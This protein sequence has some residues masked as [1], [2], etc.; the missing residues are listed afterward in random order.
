MTYY[1]VA[2]A[3]RINSTLYYILKDHL[4]SA[5]VVTDA[6][7]TILGEQ[8][9]YPFG[10]TRLTTGTIYTD[11]LFTG[12]REMAGL[13]IYH[14]QARFYSPK[15][16][17]FLSADTIVPN[18]ANPQSLNRYSY[19]YN[20]PL[21][22]V[23]PSGHDPWWCTSSDCVSD[24]M[25]TQQTQ[26][27]A[28]LE[29]AGGR[30]NDDEDEPNEPMPDGGLECPANHPNCGLGQDCGAGGMNNCPQP[31]TVVNAPY[32]QV[33]HPIDSKNVMV[34]IPIYDFSHHPPRLI[35]YRTTSYAID[36]VHFSPVDYIIPS[37]AITFASTL[38]SLAGELLKP[39][40]RNLTSMGIVTLTC[41]ECTVALEI[42]AGLDS[43]NG[44]ITF[45]A[46][47]RTH[48]V[49]FYEPLFEMPFE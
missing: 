21:N 43:A 26:A 37:D 12:Q 1:P 36:D 48:D 38:K 47:L 41:P 29:H 16:G 40:L 45:D 11:K 24:W 18:Y 31:P 6:S 19:V 17:R 5:S 9:Y 22:Y 27:Q 14:Y 30:G 49:Y 28:M 3:M 8:R 39:G 35:G 46:H 34:Q 33:L 10:E 25:E 7:G 44:S 2:G 23:D 42:M 15:T 32:T 4:G 20:A 13:G